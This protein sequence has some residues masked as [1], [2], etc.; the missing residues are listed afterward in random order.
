MCQIR[1]AMCQ[2]RSAELIQTVKVCR[3]H[4]HHPGDSIRRVALI[5]HYPRQQHSGFLQG[6]V[7]SEELSPDKG[8]QTHQKY[9]QPACPAGIFSSEN[10]G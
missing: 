4:N 7:N 2:I 1:S 3:P 9:Q 5:R 8:N 6:L 10:A